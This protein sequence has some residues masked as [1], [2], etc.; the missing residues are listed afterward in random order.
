EHLA[1]K[2][3]EFGARAERNRLAQGFGSV[4]ARIEPF[5]ANPLDD[6]KQPAG[7]GHRPW[8][9]RE[10]RLLGGERLHHWLRR[11]GHLSLRRERAVE[12]LLE[13]ILLRRDGRSEAQRRGRDQ[14]SPAH[15]INHRCKPCYRRASPPQPAATA[16][17]VSPAF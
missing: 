4:I 5:G 13:R 3:V 12:L 17:P 1:G 9:N 7:V 2:L 14:K 16:L 10:R 15:H 8:L 6:A 11:G